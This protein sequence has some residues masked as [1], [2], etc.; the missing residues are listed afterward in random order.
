MNILHFKSDTTLER[1][2]SCNSLHDGLKWL[3]ENAETGRYAIMPRKDR[4]MT[5]RAIH[6]IDVE[7]YEREEEDRDTNP[8]GRSVCVDGS[9]NY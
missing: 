7:T 1:V 2:R 4:T 8:I 5:M 3:S 9:W 6:F